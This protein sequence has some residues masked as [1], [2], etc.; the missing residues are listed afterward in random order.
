M[1]FE[2]QYFD[3]LYTINT[4]YFWENKQQSFS[5]ILRVLQDGGI[6]VQLCYT[7]TFL[8]KIKYTKIGFQKMTNEEIWAI[9]QNAG[10]SS[11]EWVD[12][13]KGKSF[14]ILCKK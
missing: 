14:Y 11:I 2:N 9:H 10:F 13:E 5:E 6:F 8:D 4:F 7:K 12:I 3:F 1:N